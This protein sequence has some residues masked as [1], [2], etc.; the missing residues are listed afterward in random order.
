[1][2]RKKTIYIVGVFILILLSSVILYRT[3]MLRGISAFLEN[4]IKFINTDIE[5]QAKL[6]E[7]IIGGIFSGVVTFGALLITIL[8]ENKKDRTFWE[9]ERKKEKEDRL[10][11]IRPFLNIEVKSVSSVRTERNDKDKDYVMVGN[12]IQFQYAHI[13]LSNNGYG[14]CKGIELEGNKCSVYQLDIEEKS[15]LDIY[16]I[17]IENEETIF[18]LIFCYKDIFGN[19]YL[20]QFTCSLKCGMRELKIEI[21][22]PLLKRGEE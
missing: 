19:S 18:P 15:E 12:G 22:E 20:Q 21:G 16:F 7:N 6:F 5:L 4:Y 11:T 3:R 14:K 2:K 9:R 17:G 10:L 8:Y 13:V 1:M